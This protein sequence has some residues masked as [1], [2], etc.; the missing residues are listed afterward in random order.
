MF[1]LINIDINSFYNC[2]RDICSTT[3]TLRADMNNFYVCLCIYMWWNKILFNLES[4]V[5]IGYFRFEIAYN[6]FNKTTAIH[7]HVDIQLKSI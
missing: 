2:A 5:R 3:A 4:F 6:V 7:I 1:H